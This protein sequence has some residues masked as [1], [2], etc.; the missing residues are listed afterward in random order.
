MSAEVTTTAPRRLAVHWRRPTELDNTPSPVAP[1]GQAILWCKECRVTIVPARPDK[2]QAARM[3][4]DRWAPLGER[5][6]LVTV[7][8]N[9]DRDPWNM[10]GDA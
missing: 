5:N 3:V 1:A 8:V 7:F 4:I 10:A 6:A 2:G 9:G